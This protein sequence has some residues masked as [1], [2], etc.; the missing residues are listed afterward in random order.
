MFEGLED[1]DKYV[2]VEDEFHVAAKTFTQHL[3]HA[4]YVRLKQLAKSRNTSKI[5][6]IS[7]PVDSRAEMK[8]DTRRTKTPETKSKL[9]K[10]TLQDVVVAK[11]AGESD[12]DDPADTHEGPWAGTSLQGLMASPKRAERSLIAV[13]GIRSSTRAAAGFTKAANIATPIG[14]FT[15][16]VKEEH[17]SELTQARSLS[18][19]EA[20]A[21]D[22]DGD[23]DDDLDAPIYVK[24]EDSA[25]RSANSERKYNNSLRNE[26]ES[27]PQASY[28]F[29]QKPTAL[30]GGASQ[31]LSKRMT[32]SGTEKA[33][34]DHR[35]GK[36]SSIFD[37][38]PTFLV[39]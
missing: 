33:G 20:T 28:D 8:E 15:H 14:R 23:D 26:L 24:V 35:D 27:R 16:P 38:I 4:E 30:P 21:S 37:E 3:H 39:S 34:V 36:I 32:K 19:D 12:L 6:T 13:S 7:R 1:D 9:Q 2:M 25:R 10:N 29:L 5:H 11:G 31:L 17:T 18:R 22:D